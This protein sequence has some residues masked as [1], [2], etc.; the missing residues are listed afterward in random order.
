VPIPAH[1]TAAAV[2]L[3]AAGLLAYQVARY[4]RGTR[5]RFDLS[6]PPAPGSAEFARLVSAMA[7]TPL[8]PGN[9]VVIMRN[10]T[11]LEAML[12]AISSAKATIDLSSYIYW[13]GDIADRF[14]DAL[15]ERAKAGVEVNVVFD[16]Y[17]SAKLDSRRLDHLERSGVNIAIYRPPSPYQVR[18]RS[19]S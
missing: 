6:D 15:V 2:G 3:G 9:R 16:G 4:R 10:G 8:R 7:G 18:P 5:R 17:G 12:E 14:S 1:R 19:V 13:P 11:S